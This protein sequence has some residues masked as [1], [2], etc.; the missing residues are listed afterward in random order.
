MR[1]EFGVAYDAIQGLAGEAGCAA[2]LTP[3]RRNQ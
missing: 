2:M 1:V 3:W